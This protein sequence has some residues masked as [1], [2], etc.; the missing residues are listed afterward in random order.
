MTEQNT[1]KIVVGRL[2]E[3]DVA[4]GYRS[5]ADVD[6]MNDAVAREVERRPAIAQFVIACDWRRCHQLISPP[7]AARIV[8]VMSVVYERIE[9]TAI[10]HD[11]T[12]PTS[13]LQASR[14]VNESKLAVPARRR[15]FAAAGAMQEWL[16]EVLTPEER[17]R[18]SV[19]L[20]IVRDSR[21][22]SD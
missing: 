11:P 5:V 20:G 12:Y 8:D 4:A 22:D 19:F 1:C 13:V 6:D 15:A 17:H 3:V 7:V 21:K 9:R 14:L 18:L 10:L 2:I 16:A